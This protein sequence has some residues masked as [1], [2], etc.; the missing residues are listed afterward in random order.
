MEKLSYYIG[1]ISTCE[2]AHAFALVVVEMI[3]DDESKVD[4]IKAVKERFIN[5]L[6]PLAPKVKTGVSNIMYQ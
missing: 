4:K 3:D 1:K 6:T 5:T 2:D